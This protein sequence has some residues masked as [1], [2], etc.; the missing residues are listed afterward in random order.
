MGVWVNSFSVCAHI[1]FAMEYIYSKAEDEKPHGGAGGEK[2]QHKEEGDGRR[3]QDEADRKKIAVEYTHTLNEQHS[4]VY[5]ICNGQ[6]APSTVNVQESLAIGSEQSK[7][8]SV[9]LSIDFHTTIQK[10]V[11]PM[12]ALTKVTMKGKALYDVKTLFSRLMVVG[13]QRS[14]EVGDVFQFE[15]SPVP[16]AMIDEYG[17]LRKGDK[18]VFVKCLGVSVTSPPTPGP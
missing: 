7:Q 15:L 14:M 5:N 4:R 18:A 3:R 16:S 13:Q 1:D 6:V 9:S 8:F 11:T 2:N 17:C 12:E 10:K